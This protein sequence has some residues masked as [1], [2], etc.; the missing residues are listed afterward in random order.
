M[1]ES[2]PEGRAGRRIAIPLVCVG[3][4]LAL[5]L[6]VPIRGWA[7]TPPPRD[8]TQFTLEDLMN[9]EVISVSKKEQKLAKTGAAIFVI[10]QEDIRRSGA[11]NIPDLLR[12]VPG[13]DVARVDHSTWAIGIRGFNGVYANKVLV[14]IDGRSVYHPAYSGVLWHAQDLPLEDLER[15]EVIRGPGGTVWGANAMNG[16]INII[17]KSATDTPGGLLVAGGGSDAQAE[18]LIQYGGKMGQSGNYRVYG[19]YSNLGKSDAAAFASPADSK[20]VQEVGFRSDWNLSPRDLLTVQGEVR[21]VDGGETVTEVIPQVPSVM[22]TFSQQTGDD[23]GNLLARWTHRY[24][25]GSDIS[26]QAYYD[27]SHAFTN[28]AD[29]WASIGNIDFQHHLRIASRNDVVWGLSYRIDA[30]RFAGNAVVTLNPLQRTDSLYSAFAQ[31]EITITRS[32]SLTLGSKFEHNDYTGF[33][34]EPS[35]QLVWA[36]TARH[37]VWASAARAIRQ[38]S[39]IDSGLQAVSA[40]VPLPQGAIGLVTVSGNPNTK[41]E[42]L[43]DFETGYRAQIN[44]RLSLDVTGF[45]S[46]YQNLQTAEPLAPYFALTGGFPHFVIPLIYEYQAHAQSYGAEAFATWNATDRW[47]ISPGLTMLNL[48][49]SRDPSS[50]DSTIALLSGY[51]PRRSYQVRS[52]VNLG[53]S[54]E[55]DQTIGYTG[56]LATGG[57][58]GY[59]RLDLRFGWR[60][61]E[62]WDFSI[63]GQ[64]LLQPRHA[65]FPDIDF[66]DHMQDQ[67]SIF[68]K[69]TWRF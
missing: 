14:L 2:L 16:V 8:L 39:N 50:Q 65:E 27:Q 9:V 62:F 6:G 24:L 59:V 38:P 53:R 43:R 58:P 32:L 21:L 25:N 61:G 17:T 64:N 36:P 28:G 67:R 15:I 37:T 7:Q 68:G 41:V 11:T 1:P 40:V 30:N 33:E 57:I 12:M 29:D 55:W 66:I 49:V 45:L 63:V 4:A 22:A 23:D 26:L 51:S 5:G 13:V 18:G 54:F 35:A 31:D 48:S 47:K 19:R 10:T 69:I 52:F 56:P 3:V 34:I 20:R 46:F 42:Q 44:R 60:P